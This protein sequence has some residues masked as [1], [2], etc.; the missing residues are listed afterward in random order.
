MIGMRVI[1]LGNANRPGVKEEAEKI[2]PF[3]V[4]HA[5]LVEMDLHQRVDLG[6]LN[7]DLALVL[8]GDGAILRAARQMAYH[9][10]PVLG[11]NLGKL[12]FLADLNV[13]ELFEVFPRVV[14]GNHHVTRHLMFECTWKEES[15]QRTILGLNEV[16]VHT[17]ESCHMIDLDLAMDGQIATRFRG[18]GLL[19]STPIGST[20]H[21]LSAGGPILSQELEAF[22]IT[23]ICPH[24]LVSRPIVES[25][26]KTYTVSLASSY[27]K[28][29][30]VVD[31]QEPIPLCRDDSIEVKRAPVSFSLIKV[32]GKN[33]YHTLRDK[34]GWGIQPS[35]RPEQIARE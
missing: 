31:G 12:G 27:A 22:V 10:A 18:D 32:P 20:A 11:V 17:D 28:A 2:R 9:Q 1:I 35:Y 29:L 33:F 24:T 13:E 6:R 15:Q 30:L 21:S 3:I 8:G 16:L 7:F 14:K 23:P 26:T 5:D 4:Q 34:L 25:C 19:I